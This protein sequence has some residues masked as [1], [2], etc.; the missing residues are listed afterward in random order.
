[1]AQKPREIEADEASATMQIALSY[2]G[3]KTMQEA[4]AL[5][6]DVPPTGAAAAADKWLRTAVHLI[7]TRRGRARDLGLAYYRL[8]RA[9][10]TGTT[11]ADPRKPEPQYVSIEKLRREFRELVEPVLA[12]QPPPQGEP[13]SESQTLPADPVGEDEFTIVFD[14][15][16]DLA[17]ETDATDDIDLDRILVEE[18]A[19]LEADQAR[20]EREAEAEA[21]IVL[22][23]LGPAN[24]SNKLQVIDVQ[25][26]AEVVDAQRTEAHASAG[27]RQAAAGSRI[28]MNG[29]RGT[30][31]QV[32]DR[33]AR[34]IG[35][36]R[37]SRTGTPCGWCA[38]LISRGPA[39]ASE[40]SATYSDGDLYHDN[41]HCYA[42]PV[43]SEQQY[44]SSP[45]FALNREYSALWPVITRGLGGKDA[46]SE[47]RRYF[48]Q[49]Q[50]EALAAA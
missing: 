11:I 12:Q 7:L 43:F 28:V 38:M 20:L 49:K 33:D 45:L 42:V 41:C 3:V 50:K 44:D 46:I 18:I 19:E 24:L 25:D 8:V 32:I 26:P 23:A 31:W 39:Y 29:A 35:Y 13:G 30:L 21:R 40:K 10:Q 2:M 22:E 34:A 17:D 37:M 48:R 9:L 5:W 6:Q 14:D 1:M 16:E 15:P 47:W 4:I 27:S 36:V